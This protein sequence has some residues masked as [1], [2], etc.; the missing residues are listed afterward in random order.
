MSIQFFPRIGGNSSG[1]SAI[2]AES[3]QTAATAYAEYAIKLTVRTGN[4]SGERRS[5]VLE[6][7]VVGESQD[8][9]DLQAGNIAQ[10]IENTS[11]GY[12]TSFV[13]KMGKFRQDDNGTPINVGVTQYGVLTWTNGLIAGETGQGP[14]IEMKGQIYIPFVD[15]DTMANNLADFNQVI[16]NAGL[17]RAKF[18][19][20]TRSSYT[21]ARS[22]RR[23]AVKI[24]DYSASS[25]GD[26]TSND[27]SAGITDGVLRDRSNSE[28]EP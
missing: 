7:G 5:A 9:C 1:R 20:D 18:T 28:P 12:V 13:K 23:S 10:I 22:R 6:F 25:Y 19:D 17:A 14:N 16:N 11:K 24:L 26:L 15:V 3:G 27:V 8:A 2:W 4:T 21:I